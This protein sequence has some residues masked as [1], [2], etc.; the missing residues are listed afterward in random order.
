MLDLSMG[1][2]VYICRKNIL[3]RDTIEKLHVIRVNGDWA[4]LG[5]DAHP[6]AM[7]HNGQIEGMREIYSATPEEAVEKARWRARQEAYGIMNKIDELNE[8]IDELE[9]YAEN[10]KIEDCEMVDRK[11]DPLDDLF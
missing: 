4:T 6:H 11:Y 5:Y 9:E 7:V 8:K 2:V 10:L 3:G 1:A